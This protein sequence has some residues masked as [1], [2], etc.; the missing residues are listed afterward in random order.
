MAHP[1]PYDYR[2]QIVKLRQSGKT[3]SF[4]ASTL[5]Y[6]LK[7]V[8]RIWYAYQERGEKALHTNYHNS[9]R[10]SIFSRSIRAQIIEI[11]DGDQGAPYVRSKLLLQ[12][13]SEAIPHE[14][15]IQ[16]WWKQQGIERPKGNPKRKSNWTKEPCHTLQ[17]DGKG[18]VKLKN[19]DQV[20]WIKIADEATG[21]DLHTQLFPL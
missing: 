11:K 14:R 1:I 10:K 6:S 9:G 13:V 8:K 20:S 19:G 3:Y 16:R 15:T 12:N 7:S 4:I 5:G 21:S 18:Y 2:K 17:I